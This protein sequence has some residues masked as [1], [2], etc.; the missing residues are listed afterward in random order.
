MFRIFVV[1]L[2]AI[3]LPAYAEWGKVECQIIR[4]YLEVSDDLI[5]DQRSDIVSLT[6]ALKGADWSAFERIE[7]RLSEDLNLSE[8]RERELLADLIVDRCFSS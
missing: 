3:P 1:A 7:P 2:V 4:D 8:T 5:L 6:A